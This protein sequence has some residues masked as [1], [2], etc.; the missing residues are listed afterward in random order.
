MSATHSTEQEL[1]AILDEGISVRLSEVGDGAYELRVEVA[2]VACAECLVP[3]QTLSGIATDALRRRGAK[4][5]SVSVQ[6]A[7]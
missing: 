4:V 6:H 3:D 1:N 5:S 7:A 2:D